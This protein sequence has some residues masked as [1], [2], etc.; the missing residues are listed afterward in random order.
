M[1]I[2]K[3]CV[4]G[5]STLC[6]NVVGQELLSNILV[7]TEEPCNIHTKIF[8]MFTSKMEWAIINKEELKNIGVRSPKVC[9]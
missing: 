4:F 3:A 9:I 1:A 7:I 5:C 2:L 8:E 6:F